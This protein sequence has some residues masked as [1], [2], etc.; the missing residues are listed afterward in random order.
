MNTYYWIQEWIPAFRI[1]KNDPLG[2]RF[3]GRPTVRPSLLHDVH[4]V[5]ILK[6]GDAVD[7]WWNDGWWEG[8]VINAMDDGSDIVHIYLPGKFV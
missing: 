1:A 6:V 7:A 8:V 5:F 4:Q 2:M 3:L